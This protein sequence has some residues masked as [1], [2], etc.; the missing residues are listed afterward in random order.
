ME[1]RRANVA[2]FSYRQKRLR[3][4]TEQRCIWGNPPTLPRRMVG[5][6][7]YAPPNGGVDRALRPRRAMRDF[8]LT[9]FSTN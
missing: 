1:M 8:T 9:F 7:C 6:V 2:R 3:L 4:G 5:S